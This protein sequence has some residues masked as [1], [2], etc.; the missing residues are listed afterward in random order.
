MKPFLNEP[1]RDFSKE[2]HRNWIRET[3][4][5]T[6]NGFPVFVPAVVNGKRISDLKTDV[7]SNPSRS[8]EI[9]SEY[10]LSDEHVLAEAVRCSKDGLDVWKDFG[11]ER[12]IE[13]LLKAGDLLNEHRNELCALMLLETGKTVPEAEADIVEAIDFCRYYA[14]EYERIFPGR[15]VRLPGE[16]NRYFYKPKGIVGV[17]APWNFPAAI[18]TG[19]CAAPLVCGN[20]V[21]LKPAEQSSATAYRIYELFLRAGV[22]EGIFHLL[23]GKGETIGA[24]LVKHPSV[25]VIN[26]TGSREVGL[27]ILRECA[28][29]NAETKIIKRA[30]CEMGG[31]NPIIV[32]S[33]ADLDQAVE[34]AI[35]SAFGFQGQKC[36]ALSRVIVL[37]SCYDTFKSRFTEAAASLRMGPPEELSSKVGPVIDAEART[38]LEDVRRRHKDRI[39]FETELSDELKRIGNYVSPTIFE[40]KN[41]DSELLQREFFGPFVTL[42]RVPSFEQAIRSANNSDYAL[43]AGLYSRNPHHIEEAKSK[44]EAGNFY[45]NRS[46]TGAI[47]ERQPFGGYKLSGVGAKAGGPDYLKSFL[48]AVTVTENTMR[49]GFS[50]DLI[51]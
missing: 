10:S 42:L 48:E 27:S 33:D 6:R 3:V 24:A 38:R 18:L 30:L 9:V 20:A 21:L 7:H 1:T 8:S 45:V 19:M 15:S 16:E 37:D 36:S 12:R 41:E 49:R 51:R 2:I 44:I 25:S 39:I 28:E 22:P 17:I 47:V 23:P 50:E 43:T 4:L 26:F 5:K 32:D 13:I 31:K 29:V 11:A 40:E 14:S 34:G 35:H 46:I